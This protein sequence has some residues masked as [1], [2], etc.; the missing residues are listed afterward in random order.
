MDKSA[1]LG[2]SSEMEDYLE[3]IAGLFRLKGEARVT[4][5]AERL[6]VSKPSVSLAMR[7][8]ADKGL[9][10]YKPYISPTLTENGRKI[11]E[12][13]QHRHDVIKQFL[14]N[15]L[16]VAPEMAENNACRLEHVI[17]REVLDHLTHFTDFIQRCPRGGSKW[18]R[19]YEYECDP[20]KETERCEQCMVMA[21]SEYRQRLHLNPGK[22]CRM[23]LAE[24]A[25]KESG[26]IV[27]VGNLGTARRRLADMGVVCG[28]LVTV[29]KVAPLGDPME[30][31]IKGY[32]LTLRKN[33]AALVIIEKKAPASSED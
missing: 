7:V 21:L 27:Q 19:G 13:V 15:V 18:I 23:T 33:E 5:I 30:V 32:N 26:R 9:I 1:T 10:H 16:G 24:L 11:A 12:R 6:Q 4:D 31:K 25:P 14:A 3:T 17:D 22:E 8:L 2:L 28:S 29:V 20:D